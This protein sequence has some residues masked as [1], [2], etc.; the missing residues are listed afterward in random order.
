[1]QGLILDLG[2]ATVQEAYSA[3]RKQVCR[4]QKT[5]S[6]SLVYDS[7]ASIEDFA[8]FLVNYVFI[9]Q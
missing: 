8:P 3:P 5:K 2:W 7:L 4:F 1:M 9:S 6:S